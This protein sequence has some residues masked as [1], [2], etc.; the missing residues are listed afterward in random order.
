MIPTILLPLI[1]AAALPGDERLAVLAVADPPG[2]EPELVELTHQLR[3][4][5]RDREAGV[6]DVA[7][8][9]ARLM[10][11][12][13]TSTLPE[14]ER[15]YAGAMATYQAGEYPS[16]IRTLRAVIGDLEK[17]PESPESYAQWIRANLRLAH[18]ELTLGRRDA[19][20]ETL[21]RVAAVD[22][23]LQADPDQFS[24]TF[25]RDLDAARAR[26]AARPKRRVDIHAVGGWAASVFVNGRPAGTAPV[27]LDLVPGRYRIGAAA[28]ALRVPSLWVQVA[29]EPRTVVLD[30]AL[31]EALRVNAG[32]GLAVS[33]AGR[34]AAI[35][36]VGAWLAA[37]RVLAASIATEER[38]Q[39]LVGSLYDVRR[40]AIVRQG[41]VRMSAGAVPAASVGALAAFLLT[42][43]PSQAVVNSTP[44][45]TP[46]PPLQ[47]PSPAR[48]T[49]PAPAVTEA[50]AARPASTP[51]P[52]ATTTANPGA[53]AIPPSASTLA[54]STPTSPSTTAAPTAV[55]AKLDL[56]PADP[57]AA[58]ARPVAAPPEGASRAW[59]RPAAY[60][61]A[62][63]ALGLGALTAQ[64]AFSA[65][66]SYQEAAGL[67]RPDG[68][69]QDPS[70][71]RDLR[72][73]GD[74][75][76]RNAWIGAAGSLAFAAG[77]GVLGYLAWTDAGA[78]AVRF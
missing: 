13:S 66:N 76:R 68:T 38:V 36:G 74:S 52:K 54:T 48:A 11:Q 4:A 78:P 65:R 35:V 49:P 61:S 25:R 24:P 57:K 44:P 12:A 9:R 73:A 72:S 17:L 20:R 14:L 60:G 26:I 16:T 8:L 19:Y 7:E 62:V 23:R 47:S 77:A 46:E 10:G 56:R 6:L 15:A 5:C 41:R 1:L 50:S 30:F 31:A 71:Y 55:P 45:P 34:S 22:P 75:A 64:Q 21:E 37:D 18:A 43:Q 67:V 59:M 70:R 27:A 58:L 53:T 3:A 69:L 28:G 33:E 39:F 29:D 51:T 32:P 2:P 42:G 40:G 63:L